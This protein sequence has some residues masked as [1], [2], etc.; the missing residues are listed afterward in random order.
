MKINVL[1]AVVVAVA[2]SAVL[3][4]AGRAAAQ[5]PNASALTIDDNLVK[6]GKTLWT[7]RACSGCHSIGKGKLAGPDLA[8]LTD[9]RTVEW[10]QKW[11]GNTTSMLESDETAKALLA[12]YNNTKMPD[13]KMKDEDALAVIH[14]IAKESQKV[15]KK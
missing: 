5:D 4:P 15:K 3:I 1:A 10:V 6:K 14:Y 13:F 8:H 11:L 2:A 9:R 12:E 7:Q